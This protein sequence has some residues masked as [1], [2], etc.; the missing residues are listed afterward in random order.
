M[1]PPGILAEIKRWEVLCSLVFVGYMISPAGLEVWY[2]ALLVVLGSFMV[3]SFLSFGATNEFEIYH[4]GFGPTEMR[5]IFILIN[6]FIIR[7]EAKYFEI[8][9]PLVVCI[10]LAGL[11]VNTYRI[12]KKLWVDDMRTKM[13]NNLG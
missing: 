4:Y 8:L 11:I 5:I 13:E 7:F 2:F 3:N 6:T 1:P 9:L 10:C 12:Q